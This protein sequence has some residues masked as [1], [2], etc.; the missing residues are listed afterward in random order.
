MRY[1]QLRR[2]MIS[3]LAV[4]GLLVAFVAQGSVPEQAIDDNRFD[5]SSLAH[6]PAPET[7]G[8]WFERSL[9]ASHCYVFQANVVRIGLGGVRTL[10]IAHEVMEGVE[11]ETARFLDGPAVALERHGRIGR[12][13][14]DENGIQSPASPTAIVEHLEGLYRLK[15]G[16]EE[17]VANRR[18]LR[19]DIDPLDSFRFGHRLWLDMA[20]GLVL[21]QL[22]LDEGGRIVETLQVTGL[23]S[24]RL[25]D[26]HV[27]ID[28]QRE[29]PAD[30]WQLGWLPEG[31]LPMPVD[32]RSS[33]HGDEVVHRLYSD[34]LSTLSLFI[35]PIGDADLLIP[36]MHRLGV[37]HAAVRHRELNGR[38]TQ[39]VV[40]GEMPPR[41]LLR[42]ADTLEWPDDDSA[43][44]S[45]DDP[46]S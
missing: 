14:W 17:R 26:G 38:P 7:P 33:R 28:R 5:C 31:F 10:T 37:A 8:E 4:A 21:K 9:W 15:L 45:S 46:A 2:W 12:F 13:G 34:G 23:E 22:L 42:V 44:S 41:V 25:H 29:P 30:S 19:L 35:E 32:T 11:R 20:T 36:G 3:P 24:P 6:Q 40:M 27:M 18:A 16:G 43:D 39:V 1:R